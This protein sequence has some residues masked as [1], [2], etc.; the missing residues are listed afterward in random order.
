MNLQL[1]FLCR[2]VSKQNYSF[3]DFP[4]SDTVSD[5]PHNVD[6]ENYIR[7]YFHHFQLDKL[8]RFHTQ[9]NKLEK[10]GKLSLNQVKS[11]LNRTMKFW[12]YI[13]PYQSVMFKPEFTP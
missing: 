8:V 5:F 10:I 9:V 7:D 13:Y 6:M 4:F 1:I 2:N 12:I 11:A 3:S